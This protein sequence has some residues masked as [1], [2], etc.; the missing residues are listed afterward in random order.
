MAYSA[1]VQAYLG[2]RAIGCALLVFMD[3]VDAPSRWWTGF[4]TLATN[5]GQV[6]QGTGDL[7]NI[8]GL[9]ED[10]GTAANP[11]TFTLSAAD[12]DMVAIV[13]NQDSRARGRRCTV[14][15]QF[16]DITPDSNSVPAWA[17]LDT[18]EVLKTARIDSLRYIASG[19]NERRI[20]CTAE[21]LWTARRKPTF[22]LYTDRDQKGRFA[23]DRGLEQ[24][25][26]LVNKTIVWPRT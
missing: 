5:D 13:R 11:L 4:G 8:E 9:E 7:I 17:P 21:G 20:I 2:G 14:S 16:F 18:P 10:R 12:P 24:V 15:L 3:F 25:T 23:G 1:T 26:D 6:W 19:P 22:G